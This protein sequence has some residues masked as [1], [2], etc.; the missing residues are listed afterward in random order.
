VIAVA[1][2]DALRNRRSR[3]HKRGDHSICKVG[4][5]A[6]AGEIR[7][8]DVRELAR[9]VEREFVGD[10]VRL[11][12]ARRLVQLASGSGAAAVSALRALVDLVEAKR[13][14]PFQPTDLLDAEVIALAAEV[15]Q[16]AEDRAFQRFVREAKDR[17]G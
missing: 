3:L 5:C 6:A 2:S 4:R 13:G 17:A 7:T 16:M 1:D 11:A 9:A 8:A 12:A 10:A 15:E 14:R